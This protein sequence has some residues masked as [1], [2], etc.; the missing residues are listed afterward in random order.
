ML[1]FKIPL[2]VSCDGNSILSVTKCYCRLKKLQVTMYS[3]THVTWSLGASPNS[4]SLRTKRIQNVRVGET[5]WLNQ[6]LCYI[7][8]TITVIST[9]RN[10][11]NFN[12]R[13]VYNKK[14]L[15][16]YISSSMPYFILYQVLAKKVYLIINRAGYEINME[17]F[18]LHPPI[19]SIEIFAC[20]LLKR[21]NIKK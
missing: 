18:D 4:E 3:A 1:F 21:N 10:Y 2:I 14:I 11:Y 9:C 20:S 15:V 7:C 6:N 13:A 16:L 12:M 19:H 17:S 8:T 5:E